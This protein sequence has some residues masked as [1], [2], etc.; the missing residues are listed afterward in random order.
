[1]KGGVGKTTTAVNLA[2]LSAAA[3][4]RTLLWDLDPQGA[5]SFAFRVR[6]HV[7]GF[8]RKTLESGHALAAAIKQTDYD[9]LDLLPADF[10]YRKLDRLIG[11]LGK[12]ERAV[13]GFL[14]TLGRG[15]DAVWLDC[16]PG[17]SLLT[18][19]VFAAVDMVLAPTIPT[20]LSLRTLA[21]LIKL[22]DRPT[23]APALA[24]F[25]SMVDCRK[26]LHRRVFEWAPRHPEVFLAGQ[27]PY[28]SVVE[29]MAVRRMPLPVFAARDPAALAF[30]AILAEVQARLQLAGEA[31]GGPTSRLQVQAIQSS[32]AGLD[33]TER[34]PA[35]SWMLKEEPA[36][37]RRRSV[38][39][40]LRYRFPGPGA[41]RLRARTARASGTLSSR[42]CAIGTRRRGRLARPEEAH[43]QID[44]RWGTEILLGIRSLLSALERR[45]GQPLPRLIGHLR[46]AV[47]E[48]TLRRSNSR[49]AE[50]PSGWH[51]AVPSP[52][53]H[54]VRA[55]AYKWPIPCAGR[56]RRCKAF[57]PSR[58]ECD[59]RPLTCR[60]GTSSE[61]HS[62][63]AA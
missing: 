36:R 42:G 7:A 37:G 16:P 27:V 15:Y 47:G 63:G 44:G 23:R 24:A 52:N 4:Q 61:P 51:A 26:A 39:R 5:S 11:R 31:R 21:D 35:A 1:M 50:R 29:Q 28:A 56:T 9:S 30:A 57:P 10:A 59:E 43:A 58:W 53:R 17:F 6:P 3:G 12:P 45:L 34:A 33:G 55:G 14:A 41:A 46:T 40:Q 25:F 60:C 32:I 19:G 18:E 48:R 8:S 62:T 38:R 49:L 2:Y 22:A 20:V 54:G 13:G